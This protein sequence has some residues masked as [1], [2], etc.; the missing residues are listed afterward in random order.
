MLDIS[1]FFV[2]QGIRMIQVGDP[3]KEKTV[4]LR[5]GFSSEEIRGVCQARNF[6][7]GALQSEADVSILKKCKS[8]G[9]AYDHLEKWHDPE[10]EVATKKLHDTFHDFII[11]PNSRP[12]KALHALEDTNNQI[13]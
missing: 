3:P 4:L 7:D 12:I 9:E 5:E 2:G 11:P 6:I 1:D 8:P 10:S 13:S